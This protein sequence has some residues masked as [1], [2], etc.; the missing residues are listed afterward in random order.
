MGLKESV[1]AYVGYMEKSIHGLMHTRP[2]YN[3]T[4]REI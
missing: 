2:Y 4:L 1:E 3:L